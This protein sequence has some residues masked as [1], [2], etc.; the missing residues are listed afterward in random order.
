MRGGELASRS[1]IILGSAL[2]MAVGI[3]Q[4]TRY[5]R[6]ECFMPGPL[7]ADT[8]EVPGI[9]AELDRYRSWTTHRLHG[10]DAP[11]YLPA[12]GAEDGLARAG[13]FTNNWPLPPPSL[14]PRSSLRSTSSRSSLKTWALC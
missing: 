8:S 14:R 6:A 2:L 9:V 5:Q 11:G 7:A 1:A 12:A 4:A 13:S 10:K 3:W